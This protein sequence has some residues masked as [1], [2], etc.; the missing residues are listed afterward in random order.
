MRAELG[1]GTDSLRH[2]SRC[3]AIKQRA[4]AN[5]EVDVFI[6]IHIPHARAAA[7]GKVERHRLLHLADA[8]VHTSGDAARGALKKTTGVGVTIGHGKGCWA[9]PARGLLFQ[10]NRMIPIGP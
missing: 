7:V 5:L 9:R 4:L 6:A 2:A 3:M 8:T 10:V 1:L